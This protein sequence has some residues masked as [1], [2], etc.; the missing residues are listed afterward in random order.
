MV[1]AS[2]VQVSLG[3][4]SKISQISGDCI[5]NSGFTGNNIVQ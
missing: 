3:T 2:R 4:A 5:V 1:F